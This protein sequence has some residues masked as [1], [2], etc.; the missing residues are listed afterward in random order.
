MNKDY[1]TTFPIYLRRLDERKTIIIGGDE[2]AEE[3]VEQLL[4]R[5]ADLTVISPNLTEKLKNLAEKEAF[6]WV[7]RRYQEGDLEGAFMV[8]AAETKGD[9]NERIYREANER[10]Q[11]VNVMDDIPNANF[12][13]GSIVKQGPLTISISTSG[14]APALAVRLRERFEEEFGKE[15]ADFLK[16][17]QQLRDPMAR[18]HPSFTERKELW[19]ELIDSNVL[20]LF[21]IGE[22]ELAIQ[23]IAAIVGEDVVREATGSTGNVLSETGSIISK[24]KESVRLLFNGSSG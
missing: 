12:A 5:D 20:T 21:R 7:D 1:L 16:F 8:I 13:F 23:R 4:E 22:R 6:E 24:M 17:M 14:A 2:E 3:K 9:E 19:Y 15:Y 18:Y 11:L 10:D